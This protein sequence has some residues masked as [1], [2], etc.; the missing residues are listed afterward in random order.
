MTEADNG[1]HDPHGYLTTALY[2]AENTARLSEHPD[3]VPAYRAKAA[4]IWHWLPEH[5]R[6][7][8]RQSA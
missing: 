7:A 8:L 6:E 3:D 2:D 1:W 5:V 4:A